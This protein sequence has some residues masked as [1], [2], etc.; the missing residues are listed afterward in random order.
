LGLF[1]ALG[2][3]KKVFNKKILTFYTKI[4]SHCLIIEQVVL[5]DSFSLAI[6]SMVE[7]LKRTIGRDQFIISGTRSNN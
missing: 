3:G 5:L 6:S 7:Q 2:I 4:R 1:Y